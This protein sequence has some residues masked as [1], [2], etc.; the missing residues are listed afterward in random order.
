MNNSFH[1]FSLS[2]EGLFLLEKSRKI[3]ICNFIQIKSVIIDKDTDIETY[4]LEYRRRNTNELNTRIIKSEDIQKNNIL[5]LS[6]YG[7]DINDNNKSLASEYLSTSL[8]TAPIKI[9][10]NGYGWTQY[11]SQKLFIG[12]TIL[13]AAP[14]KESLI[15]NAKKLDLAPHGYIEAWLTMYNEYILGNAYLE[16]AVVFGLSAPII[17]YLYES[18]P[19]LATILIH[20]SG[21]STAG[22]STASMLAVS[23]AGNPN[24]ISSKS[25][26]RKWS[27]TEN[28]IMAILE[29][30]SGVPIAF[31]ELSSF[32]GDNLT[33]L[34]YTLTDGVGK[35]RAK[36]DGS[37]TEPKNWNT[38]ILSNGEASILTKSNNNTGLKAR[39]FEFNN[40]T[41]TVS[42][43]Q[44]EIIKEVCCNNYGHILPLF[45]R[46]LFTYGTDK[47]IE[48]F[49][50]EKQLLIEKFPNSRLKDRI[51]AKFAVFTTTARLLKETGTL[52]I[53]R[54]TVFKLLHEQ[55]LSAMTNREI[56]VIAYEK[57]LQYL[58]AHN[59]RLS[60]N[61]YKQLGFIKGE[62]IFVIKDQLN[63]IFKEL[64][65]ED[66]S[67]I[68][69]DW[70]KR[71]YLIK[72]EGDRKTTRKQENNETLIGYTI[73]IPKEYRPHFFPSSTQRENDITQNLA[74]ILNTHIQSV[75]DA[76]LD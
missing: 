30:I 16:L 71:D 73:K 61:S 67:I 9:T 41:W 11:K 72:P 50:E 53:N 1:T 33:A 28:S 59:A 27:G 55:E 65:F 29:D 66:L 62:T 43:E 36:I 38:I 7:V 45:V 70:S 57:L 24:Q 47:I 20:I 48:V 6:K 49:E 26:M 13:S 4:K 8:Q 21:D 51:V 64:G 68:I 54:D 76:N 40:I 69:K 52:E 22:K 23:T 63:T 12:D 10:L 35:A 5:S 75:D 19:D 32:R 18:Y 74:S 3:R 37:L 56:G 31:D 39:A 17:N 34:V 42:A 46:N 44:A 58:L 2:Q 60:Q 15:N 14:T 25:L